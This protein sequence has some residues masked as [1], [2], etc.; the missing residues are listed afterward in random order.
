MQHFRFFK[1]DEI[2]QAKKEHRNPVP[3][4]GITCSSKELSY[5]IGKYELDQDWVWTN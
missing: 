5:Y 1:R 3:V 2:K 4:F